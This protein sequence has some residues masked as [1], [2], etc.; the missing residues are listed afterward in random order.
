MEKRTEFYAS[1][2][3]RPAAVSSK[4]PVDQCCRPDRWPDQQQQKII[5]SCNSSSL[6][7]S[8]SR[9]KSFFF[10]SLNNLTK[11]I[12]E[13]GGKRECIK[14]SESDFLSRPLL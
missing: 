4:A 8:N 5:Q 1:W 10:P 12:V 14:S 7:Q 3:S 13:T 2:W 9:K 11:V 6:N